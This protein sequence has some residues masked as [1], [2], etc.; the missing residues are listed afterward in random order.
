MK[1]RM[2]KILALVLAMMTLTACCCGVRAEDAEEPVPVLELPEAKDGTFAPLTAAENPMISPKDR[3][4]SGTGASKAAAS[5]QNPSITVN[6]GTGRVHQTAYMYARVKIA[7]PYQLR[8]AAVEDSLAKVTTLIGSKIAARVKAVVGVNGVLE[9]DVTSSGVGARL[10][11]PVLIQGEWKRPAATSSEQKINKWR[12]DEGRE[13]LV[14]DDE[15]NLNIVTGE[16]WG[17]IYDT[18]V[19]MGDHAVNAFCFGPA[20]VVNGEPVYGYYSR[21]I[22]T[23]KRAQ[24]MAICQTGPLEY[25]LI[26]S[27]GPENPGSKGLQLDQFIELIVTEF[28]EVQTAYNLDGGSSSTLIFREGSETWAKVNCPKGG[29]TRPLRDIIYFADAWIPD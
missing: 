9:S 2:S 25:L 4:Y 23:A 20:I 15:G 27:E 12:Q 22:S 21:A 5:Y 28:P 17:D 1:N 11:G 19:A 7:S 24:R 13:T 6:L 14:I 8:I 10:A 16:T 29:K 26:T 18:I 3:F